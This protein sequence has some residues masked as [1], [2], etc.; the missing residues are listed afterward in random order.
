M[1]TQ[2]EVM[3]KINYYKEKLADAMEEKE[4][5]SCTSYP[6]LD[7]IIFS[8]VD[9]LEALLWVLEV[10]LPDGDILERIVGINH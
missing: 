2:E 8:L 5:F 9:K 10:D 4:E 3:Q 7:L 1:R 6:E